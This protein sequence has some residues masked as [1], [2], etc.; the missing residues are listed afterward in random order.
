MSINQ[1]TPNP[2]YMYVNATPNPVTLYTDDATLALPDASKGLNLY[3]APDSYIGSYRIG[4][5]TDPHQ[6]PYFVTLG[7]GALMQHIQVFAPTTAG[8][9]YRVATTQKSVAAMVNMS[10][11]GIGEALGEMQML[12]Q[13]MM[14]DLYGT[15]GILHSLTQSAYTPIVLT[16]NQTNALTDIQTNVLPNLGW[17]LGNV[18]PSGGVPDY[19]Y[20]TMKAMLPQSVKDAQE[21][22]QFV[23]NT[24]NLV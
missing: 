24:P 9:T 15:S 18:Y 5:Q 7:T 12:I 20:A 2:N 11:V 22:A 8:G 6:Q 3:F 23:A 19:H 16:A 13:M 14:N 17:T 10:S 1:P 21:Y 4:I